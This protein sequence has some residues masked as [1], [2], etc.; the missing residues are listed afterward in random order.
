M[1]RIDAI[2]TVQERR[3]NKQDYLVYPSFF[4]RR[5]DKP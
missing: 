1:K 2:G 4:F 5:L 3:K